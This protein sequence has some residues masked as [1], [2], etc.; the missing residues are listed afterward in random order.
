MV[1]C[2]DYSVRTRN[3]RDD[4]EDSMDERLTIG[5][6]VEDEGHDDQILTP[7][8][9]SLPS[10]ESMNAMDDCVGP[11]EQRR[12]INDD[13]VEVGLVR[14][15]GSRSTA[16]GGQIVSGMTGRKYH[17]TAVDISTRLKQFKSRLEGNVPAQSAVM[18]ASARA[19][20]GM[21][22]SPTTTDEVRSSMTPSALE[23]NFDGMSHATMPSDA[24]TAH[25]LQH[26]IP[27]ALSSQE[28]G[29]PAWPG[30][31]ADMASGPV[32]ELFGMPAQLMIP[33][34]DMRTM[35]YTQATQGYGV[36]AH[37]DLTMMDSP[38]YQGSIG[39]QRRDLPLRM[40][41]PTLSLMTDP[42]SGMDVLQAGY[43][44]I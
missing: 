36:D 24:H 17:E 33:R 41:Q 8:P 15:H 40:V 22:I 13:S 38:R 6:F 19:H 1:F 30:T 35:Y 23:Q 3:M 28:T 4:S 27:N 25:S 2:N 9:S 16:N 5:G 31:M 26:G 29:Y 37:G 14:G 39:S 34:P 18:H 42:H 32:E 20:S 11:A 7:E 21:H 43:Y 44:P 10:P 12:H